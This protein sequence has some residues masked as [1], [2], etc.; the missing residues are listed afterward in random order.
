MALFAEFVSGGTLQEI[1]ENGAQNVFPLSAFTTETVSRLTNLSIRQLHYWDRIGFFSPAFADPNTRRP[2]SRVYSFQDVVGLRMIA[3]LREAGVSL[4]E[5]K[6]VRALFSPGQK[7]EWSDRTF[8]TVGRRVFFTHEDAIVAARPLGQ[9]VEPGI[10]KMGPVVADVRAAIRQLH[11]RPKVQIGQVAQDR[12]I[13]RGAPVV[14]G[15]R[16]PTA[17]IAWFVRNGYSTSQIMLEFPR[18]TEKDIEAAIA[19]ENAE[20]EVVSYD[21]LAVG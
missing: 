11:V 10:L 19:F 8:Y 1:L 20:E 15:T 14:A 12:S 21:Q 18:L 17:T 3:K 13:M 9:G 5:L 6:K 4:Q 2:H 7:N 16:I